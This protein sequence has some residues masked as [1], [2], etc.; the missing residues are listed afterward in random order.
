MQI[1]QRTQFGRGQ[2]PPSTKFVNFLHGHGVRTAFLSVSI[3]DDHE[4]RD[5]GIILQRIPIAC[6]I[7]SLHMDH[8]LNTVPYADLPKRP[9]E[10]LLKPTR[11]PHTGLANGATIREPPRGA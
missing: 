11:L 8:P 10:S 4:V 2:N 9:S 1:A 3:S 7:P 6:Q 5:S